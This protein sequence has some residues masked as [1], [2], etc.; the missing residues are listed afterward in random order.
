MTNSIPF[1]EQV[2]EQNPFR[3]KIRSLGFKCA[4]A[5][6]FVRFSALPEVIAFITGVN[7]YII[8]LFGPIVILALIFSGGL[9]RTFQERAAKFWLC[10]ALWMIVAVPF[11]SWKG[12]SLSDVTS[13]LKA[14]FIMLFVTAGL[15]RTWTDCRKIIYAVAAAGVFNLTMAYLA[16]GGGDRLAFAWSGTIGNSD[17][18]AAH[19]LLVMPFVLFIGLKPRTH[20]LVRLLSIGVVGLGAL[21][22]LR[23]ASR[24]ALIALALTT[25]LLFFRGSFR[26]RAAIFAASVAIL[27]LLVF[28]IP[29][30]TFQRIT[31]FSKNDKASAEA[32]ESSEIRRYL[33]EKS[34]EFTLRNPV[35]GVGPGQFS[36]YEGRSVTQHGF[37]ASWHEAHNSYT[38][39]SSE[40]G[41]PALGFFLAALASTFVLLA[42]IRRKA[43]DADD[44]ELAAAAYCIRMALFAFT[45]AVFFLNFGYCYQF[46][47]VS[48]LVVCMWRV[49]NSESD[50]SRDV[51]TQ[52]DVFEIQEQVPEL[53]LS[54]R[55]PHKLSTSY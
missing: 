50:C 55:L 7:T 26:Q 37:M 12:G 30:A 46:P 40:C 43:A 42:R 28:F 6:V 2:D 34:I 20:F 51:N 1:T 39:V 13:Y 15:A 9:R 23:T 29:A 25:L 17:D 52:R 3:E 41:I 16:P 48:G 38:Q 21:Q 33:L 45:S 35:F 5:L 36:S 19:L 47:A 53:E 31:S 4:V 24:G 44:K 32:M 8:Y 11:S 22:I 49:V 54:N 10:F 18:F 14:Y 27:V